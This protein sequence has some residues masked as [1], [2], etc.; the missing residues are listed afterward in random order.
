MNSTIR[1]L[2]LFA[3]VLIL[4]AGASSARADTL[5]YYQVI[6]PGSQGTFIADFTIGMHPTPSGGNALAFWFT[7]LPV[8]VNGTWTNLTVAFT[9]LLGGGVAGS[10]TFALV[11]S[12][13]FTWP[14]SSSTPIMNAGVFSLTG[15]TASG[16]GTYTVTVTPGVGVISTPE[17]ATL[18]FLA[19]GSLV[20]VGARRRRLL[21]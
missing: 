15:I 14:S 20:L 12:Q 10:N 19:L 8:D 16:L 18:V 3:A 5:L 1:R 4:L 13:L 11:G 7:N 9:S 6:G 17:S 21:A 2:V